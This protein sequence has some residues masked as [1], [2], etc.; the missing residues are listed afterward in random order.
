ML[1]RRQGHVRWS[2]FCCQSA[3][4]SNTQCKLRGQSPWRSK[5][6]L[7][8]FCTCNGKRAKQWG[9]TQ[10]SSSG[11]RIPLV[12]AVLCVNVL[13]WEGGGSCRF[14]CVVDCV[15]AKFIPR[16]ESRCVRCTV[17]YNEG[18]LLVCRLIGM[19]LL[20]V[21]VKVGIVPYFFQGAHGGICCSESGCDVIIVML[22]FLVTY[23]RTEVT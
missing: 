20:V 11:A 13:V 23:I 16:G 7:W 8:P 21:D 12:L 4:N 6:K 17:C 15:G 19:A 22:N 1:Y 2:G 3:D 18:T 9:F 14:P 10:R 5:K